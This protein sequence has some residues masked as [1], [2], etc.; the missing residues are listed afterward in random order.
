MDGQRL[1]ILI[2]NDVSTETEFRRSRPEKGKENI[3]IKNNNRLDKALWQRKRREKPCSLS[4]IK[5][6]KTLMSKV[7]NNFHI[8]HPYRTSQ[9]TSCRRQDTTLLYLRVN[10]TTSNTAI[11]TYNFCNSCPICAFVLH[12][13]DIYVYTNYSLGFFSKYFL[14]LLT[15]QLNR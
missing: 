2:R 4:T 14:R 13:Y 9:T 11:F 8:L 7:S 5:R 3:L 10:I 12:N 1:R 15:C 6:R